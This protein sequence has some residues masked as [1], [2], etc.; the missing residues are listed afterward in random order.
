MSEIYDV[1]TQLEI[2]ESEYYHFGTTFFKNIEI[3]KTRNRKKLSFVYPVFWT[4]LIDYGNG[5][6]IVRR[7]TILRL[8]FRRLPVH[9]S[10]YFQLVEVSW[11]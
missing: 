2:V 8:F 5:K 6:K 10:R 4:I 7:F 9:F 1:K 3:N 11:F